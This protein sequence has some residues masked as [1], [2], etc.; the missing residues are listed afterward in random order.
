MDVRTR[1]ETLDE[2]I[3]SAV[4]AKL[5]ETHTAIPGKIVSVDFAKQTCVMQ[6]TVKARVHKPDGT[7][8]WVDLPQI[9]DVP[10]H[11]PSGGGVTLTFPVKE[12]D[13]GLIVFSGRTQDAWQQQGGDQQQVDLRPHD[14]SNAFAMVGF[15]SNPKALSGV[16]SSSTQ[17]RSDDGTQVIDIHPANGLTLTS[18]GVSMAMTPA[19]VAFTGGTIS[20]NGQNIGSTHV[21]G[22]IQ[23]GAADTGTPH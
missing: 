7:Q 3:Q 22:G 13:E 2:A 21:H 4:E 9:P 23:P 18:G 1:Y 8:D 20:H 17:I 19:G 11:F 6:P 10:L 16:S 12:G 15:K 5:A 14:A